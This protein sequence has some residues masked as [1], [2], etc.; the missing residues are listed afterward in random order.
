MRSSWRLV[1]LLASLFALVSGASEAQDL[2]PGA[3][4]IVTEDAD[5]FGFDLRTVKEVDLD[6]CKAA[7]LGDS[8]CRA[9]TYN[10]R[11]RWCFLKS[12]HGEPRLFPGAVAGRVVAG[13]ETAE[14]PPALAFLPESMP[15]E[16][17]RYAL[18]LRRAATAPAASL[19]VLL[20]AAASAL[21][22]GDARRAA[23]HFR[24]VLSVTPEFFSAWTGLAR[25]LLDAEPADY[26]ER[27]RF[28]ADAGLA[29]L[30]AYGLS[31]AGSERAEAL[32]L[33]A[34]ALE[35]QQVFRPAL[36]AYK[37]S[38]A[39]ADSPAIHAAFNRLRA[40]KG[41]RVID[42][43]VDS[44]AASPRVCVQFS[45]DLPGGRTDFLS[46]VTV[47][48]APPAAVEPEGR[49]ICV[50][51]LSHGRRYRIALRAGLPST[52]D[53][54]IETPVVLNVYVRD[55][56]PSVRFT[57]RNF[58]LP[59]AG[60]QGIPLVSVNTDSVEIELY[61]IGDRAL[62]EAVV[63][64]KF[65]SQLN[66]YDSDEISDRLGQR[67]W[68]GTLA[69]DT[70]LNREV[71]TSFPIDEALSERL[72]GVY[73]MVAR[74]KGDEAQTWKA[75]ATQWFIVS[76][77]GLAGITGSDGLNV[78]ARSLSSA[79]PLADAALILVARNNEVLGKAQTDAEGH[80]IFE[81]GLT[82]GT[83]GLAPALVTASGA[84][85]DY[86]FLDLTAPGFDLS[87]RGV[88]GREAPQPIDA[89]LY[90]ERGIYRP[91]DIV[92]LV[93]L[94]RD[95]QA[96]AVEGLPLTFIFHRP[97]GVEYR[98]IVGQD[99]GFGGYAVAFA[100]PDS[101][102][103]GTWRVAAHAA[104]KDP[105]IAEARFLVE[106]FVPDRIEFDLTAEADM[107]P[108]DGAVAAEVEG[109]FLYGAPA[110]GLRL[111]GEITVKPTETLAAYPGYR[112]GL[113][114]E[115]VAPLREP[116]A[117]LAVTDEAGHAGFDLSVGALPDTTRPLE[118]AVTVRMREGGGRAV[119][120][121]LALPVAPESAMIGIR[122][123]FADDRV[124]EGENAGFSVIAIDEAGRRSALGGLAWQL[125][126]VERNYQWYRLNGS[127][128]FEAVD[129]TRR[130]ADGRIDVAAGA[131]ARI[132]ARV[133]W[134]LYRLEVTGAGAGAPA[135]SIDFTAGWYVE[136]RAADTPDNLQVS[137][138]R[139]AYGPGDM[140]TV[141]FTA[142]HKG[143]ALVTV[144]GESLIAL[145]AVEVD[146]GRA[147]VELPVTE[148]WG[149][150]AYV[151]VSLYRPTDIAAGHMPARALGLSWAKLDTSARTLNISMD[152]PEIARP[153]GSLTVPLRLAGL[154]PGEKAFLTV[155]AVDVGILNVTR[156]D[157]PAPEAWYY[158]Q[159]KL[160]VEIRDVY[161][162]LIDG[163]Q[164]A[165]GQIRSGGDITP[166]ALA[167]SPPTQEPV[168]LF[169][170]IVETDADGRAQVS[171]D[172]PQYNGTLRLMA[173]AWSAAG[174]GHGVA[175]VIVRD[176]V[177][178]TASLPRFL[179]PEDSSRLRLDIDNREGPA[180][181]YE[182]IV[183]ASDEI[184][185]GTP[186]QAIELAAESRAALDVTLSA[187]AVGTGELN[188]RLVAPDG[189]EISQSLT[190]AVRPAE[191]PVTERRIVTL[192]PGGRLALTADMLADRV[193]GT[194]AVSVSIS[195][196]GRLDMPSFLH[197]L[198]RYPYGCAEQIASRALPL[199]YLSEV[200]AASGLGEEPE[201]RK[202]IQD[203]VYKLAS[204]QSA[205]GGFGLWGPGSGDLWLDA[206]VT[207]FLT[208]AGER[209]FEVPERTFS[210]ALDNL[211]NTL[212]FSGEV[213][214]GG[215]DIAYALY[216]LA[217]NRRAAVGDLR[218][219]ADTKLGDFAS[220]LAKAQIGA[221]LALY[222]ERSRASIAFAA[223]LSVLRTVGPENLSRSDYGTRLR[224]GAAMLALA[225]EVA[226]P[227][228]PLPQL[229][230]F[231]AAAQAEKRLTSTQ[232][233]AWLLLAAH[234]LLEGDNAIALA[235]DGAPVTGNFVRNYS[236]E[237]LAAAPVSIANT[238][239]GPVEAVL[240]LTGVRDAPEPSGGEGFAI[241]RAYYAL[242]GTPVDPAT[243]GQN[244]RFVVVL[245][246]REDNAWPSRVLVVDMLPA[247]FEIDNPGLVDSADLSAFAWLAE[248]PEAAHLE[249]RDDRF[250]AALDRKGDEARGFTL[251]YVVRAVSPGRYV[252]PAALVE[253][254]Y[255][256]H[257]N[258]RTETGRTEVVWV[259]AQ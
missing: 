202:R 39:E 82:R 7:C 116:L 186:R 62:A 52:V 92:H 184:A 237:T 30:N 35:R 55:R 27:Y 201:L 19:T 88:A 205:A 175:D 113:A 69:V 125:S 54:V 183:E 145:Q 142:R 59:R 253:D 161:G 187:R 200:A 130:V 194:G 25:A 196:A 210:Q 162:Q 215:A 219:Y 38:L 251:A 74:P 97:D 126:K 121:A 135:T 147:S 241:G 72:P 133:E 128:S 137:L 99:A 96:E 228:V 6:Q 83:G 158:G 104:P 117:G 1:F 179:A 10:V 13:P 168:S 136:A 66:E 101:A 132:E 156:F 218:Y 24:G 9:F 89:F 141:S 239:D 198:D 195:R 157:P 169:S 208:R 70:E 148:A 163:M 95:R 114:D 199:L 106:D 131:P 77:I 109:R 189:A 111:E 43:S 243:V 108:R 48:G 232:E 85:G 5:Y 224:D 213:T 256:P 15:E 188:V 254:M 118:A 235:L 144:M 240:T 64:G 68:Q 173:V 65:L 155:A 86:A 71:T 222:G 14:R 76:D 207:D 227:L 221:A 250:V 146:E 149:A 226:P 94:A 174:V 112:F 220:P 190:L 180:G 90:T 18:Q 12:D 50:E 21:A 160:G 223:A 87:D 105:A 37:A 41:F 36:E 44:D 150:G 134:G 152:A 78:F 255:R 45:E 60:A 211:R 229:V 233:N 120:R 3:R 234:A 217:R 165:R 32:A 16:A 171:F 203:A 28:P 153:R 129:F 4:I 212:S 191:P 252:R 46:F 33:L 185:V 245:Q 73:V 49:Q 197:A 176:P 127:W 98:R 258:A 115:E 11:A 257:L 93:G 178:V 247:G 236:A 67:L 51:G 249:F 151:A 79:A 248:K 17:E 75:R 40:E 47:D 172:V 166:V 181:A 225:A 209:G 154:K 167:A 119:E 26:D 230:D 23:E 8:A 138:D 231:V 107:L 123:L 63:D 159:R 214:G 182:L 80:A 102:M 192:E 84:L 206:Y 140:A 110:A 100:V 139:Q 143:A 177:V 193:A 20:S 242:D 124:G 56:T 29:A 246:V 81:A 164:G 22:S 170:G 244:E 34:R 31:A 91:G 61:R 122:P 58:V 216:V 238:G 2:S 204:F 57:G 42:Y 53:E 259:R 103:R